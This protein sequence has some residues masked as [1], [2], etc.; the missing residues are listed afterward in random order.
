[1]DGEREAARRAV[2]HGYRD[3]T[4]GTRRAIAFAAA[5]LVLFVAP[6]AA[7]SS[8]SMPMVVT[9]RDAQ[10]TASGAYAD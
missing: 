9:S 8:C 10:E 6:K 7:A 1:M 3:A 4:L 2:R 5:G